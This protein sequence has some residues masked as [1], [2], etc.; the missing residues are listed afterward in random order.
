M[1]ACLIVR[2]IVDSKKKDD[3]DSWYQKEHLPDALN[4]LGPMS[5]KRGWS[6]EEPNTHV[7]IYEFASI[8]EATKATNSQEIIALIIEFDKHWDGFVTRTREVINLTH[9]M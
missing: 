8:T 6:I 4:A 3:F 1:T 5:A 7:A 9:S 2:A